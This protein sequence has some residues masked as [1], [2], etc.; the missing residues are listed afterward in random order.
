MVRKTASWKTFVDTQDAKETQKTNGKDVVVPLVLWNQPPRVEVAALHVLLLPISQP[1]QN[2]S[3]PTTE[4]ERGFSNEDEDAQFQMCVFAGTV[5][6]VVLYW[7]FEKETVAQVNML[8]F[9]GSDSLGQPIVGIVSGTD[10]WG[11]STLVTAT[12]DGAL[13]RW[14]LPN[15]A[16]AEANASLAKELAPLLGLEM[17]CNRRFAVVVSEESRLM[18]LDTW[19]MQLLYCMDTAQEQIRRSVTVGELRSTPKSHRPSPADQ[20]VEHR[21]VLVKAVVRRV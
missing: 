19:K 10:E 17:L 5:D 21:L 8:V 7:R 3:V 20:R 15:G 11:Q 12:K 4:E 2:S 6:G 14:Q 13:A 9:P 1:S 18:V 16:C